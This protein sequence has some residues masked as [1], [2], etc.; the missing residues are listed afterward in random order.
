MAWTVYNSGPLALNVT[1]IAIPQEIGPSE[2]GTFELA[3]FMQSTIL[4]EA[5]ASGG[6]CVVDYGD[7]SPSNGWSP[8]VYHLH[9]LAT[10]TASGQSDPVTL[11]PFSEY[12]LYLNV[13]ALGSSSSVAIGY[14]PLVWSRTTNSI[15]YLPPIQ[16]IAAVSAVGA[17]RQVLNEPPDIAGRFTWTVTGSATFELWLLV[18]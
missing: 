6:V 1:D 10:E 8:I 11:A 15:I 14:Q 17:I 3:D 13:T 9:P 4:A 12:I 18:R 2:S 7:F 5:V 16:E